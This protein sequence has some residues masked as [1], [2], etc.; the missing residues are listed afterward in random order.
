[1]QTYLIH[2]NGGRPFRVDIDTENVVRVYKHG[3]RDGNTDLVQTFHP[4]KVF[5]GQDVSMDPRFAGNSILLEIDSNQNIYVSI[6]Q[7]IESFRAK[8]KIISY[9]SN[10]GNSNVPYPYAI[11]DQDNYYLIIESVILTRVPKHVSKSTEIYRWYYENCKIRDYNGLHIQSFFIN[12]EEYDNMCYHVDPGKY[13]DWRKS[14]I[15]EESKESK[16]LEISILTDKERVQL[17]REEYILIHEDFAKKMGY[18]KLDL[19]LIEK[20]MY[21]W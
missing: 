16:N 21:E 5:V 4:Q 9:V 7:R 14:L 6:G 15:K 12:E 1:M 17:S 3:R 19:T 20:R 10:V 8:S 2:D 18:E 13:W 11:D